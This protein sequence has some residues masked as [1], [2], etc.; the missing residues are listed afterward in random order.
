MRN[1]LKLLQF[2]VVLSIF[3]I[4]SGICSNRRT[5]CLVSFVGSQNRFS[6]YQFS[7]LPATLKGGED[8]KYIFFFVCLSF[9]L[10]SLGKWLSTSHCYS[11][12]LSCCICWSYKPEK[13]EQQSVSRAGTSSKQGDGKHSREE[14][15]WLWALSTEATNSWGLTCL[16]GYIPEI[17]AQCTVL[18]LLQTQHWYIGWCCSEAKFYIVKSKSYW[19]ILSTVSPFLCKKI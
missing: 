8:L 1:I 4:Q 13:E 6:P 15:R 9:K 3:I 12:D 5:D 17:A 7:I 10:M 14:L 11:L 18:T 16:W 2:L 19:E